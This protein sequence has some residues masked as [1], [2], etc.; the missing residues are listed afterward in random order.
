VAV[1]ALFS[2][3]DFG[4]PTKMAGPH[5]CCDTRRVTAPCDRAVQARPCCGT[6]VPAPAAVM[7]GQ[8]SVTAPRATPLWGLEAERPPDSAVPV[9]AAAAYVRWL[10]GTPPPPYLLHRVLRI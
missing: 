7:A 9:E 4:V 1:L 2:T 8:A 6:V 10:A 3:P 5:D